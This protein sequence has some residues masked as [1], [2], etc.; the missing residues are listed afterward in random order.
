MPALSVAPPTLSWLKYHYFNTF[1][2]KFDSCCPALHWIWPL[3]Y[4]L[5][6]HKQQY[7][8]CITIRGWQVIFVHEDF[9]KNL[10]HL[11]LYRQ[12]NDYF[13]VVWT[14]KIWFSKRNV[15]HIGP[16]NYIM[17]LLPCYLLIVMQLIESRHKSWSRYW[18]DLMITLN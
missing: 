14:S 5:F 9:N 10:A 2:A 4:L 13:I 6:L 12:C 15:D 3:Y 17:C 7:F 1:N 11:N 16:T 8:I 18:S